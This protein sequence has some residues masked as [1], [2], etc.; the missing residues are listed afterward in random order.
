MQEEKTITRTEMQTIVDGITA[1]HMK[2]IE[3]EVEQIS[4][5]I[6]E[7]FQIKLQ[8]LDDAIK[9]TQESFLLLEKTKELIRLSESPNPH[10]QKKNIPW[11]L[12]W[13][14]S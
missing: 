14:Y 8:E 11:I 10:S 3:N 9:K 4:K 1:N 2:D 7:A 12:R 5:P 6:R 13:L